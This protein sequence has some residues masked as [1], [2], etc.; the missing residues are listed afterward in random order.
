[1][2][3]A[4]IVFAISG[5]HGSLFWNAARHIVIAGAL[6]TIALAAHVRW[7]ETGWRPGRA[8]SVVGFALSLTASEAALAVMAYLFA[9]EACSAHGNGN[10]RLR[11]VGPELILIAAYLAMYRWMGL[12]ASGGS[13]YVDPLKAPLA[14]F[15]QLP[16][17]WLFLV[18]AL[19]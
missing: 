2:T 10:E 13:D 18:G 1:G 9:Y 7:R 12:G 4:L 17:R 11:A 15:A 16:G 5:I 14:F 3:L 6:G 19:V 8:L